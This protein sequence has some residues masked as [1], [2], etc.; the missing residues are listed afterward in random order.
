MLTSCPNVSTTPI[1]AMG[2]RQCLL[3]SVVQLKGKHCRKPHCRNGVVDTFGLSIL[4][5]S[6]FLKPKSLMTAPH[7]ICVDIIR[8]I[9]WSKIFIAFCFNNKFKSSKLW[10]RIYKLICPIV[11][12]PTLVCRRPFRAKFRF[13]HAR[14]IEAN[15]N[16]WGTSQG[17]AVKGRRK[18]GHMGFNCPPR[19]W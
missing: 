7:Y 13:L 14:L 6:S 11:Q 18:G 19:F 9:L 10:I 2:C 12:L 17:I 15:T 8:V 5:L 1:T 3:L 4:L 16:G